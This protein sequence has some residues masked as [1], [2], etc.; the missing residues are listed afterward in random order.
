MTIPLVNNFVG[1]QLPDGAANIR[2]VEFKKGWFISHIESTG[3]L[4]LIRYPPNTS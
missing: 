2:I 4:N 1:V 3:Y